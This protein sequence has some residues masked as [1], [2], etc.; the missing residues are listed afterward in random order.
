[1]DNEHSIEQSPTGNPVSKQKTSTDAEE[2]AFLLRKGLNLRPLRRSVLRNLWLVAGIVTILGS[3]AALRS[4][5]APPTYSGEF[6]LL[7]EPL[8]TEARVADP[9]AVTRTGE[10]VPNE[11]SFGL[12]YPSQ[13]AVLRSPGMM[14]LIVA[15]VQEKYPSFN[16]GTLYGGLSV[17]R[18]GETDLTHT[19]L[20]KVSYIGTD[21]E[22]V[23]LVLKKTSERYLRYSLE[24]RKT[25]YSEG[26]KF[27]DDRLPD[28]QQRVGALQDQLQKLQEQ[29]DLISP[30]DQGQLLSQQINQ[31]ALD[32]R[33]TRKQLREQTTLY[34]SLRQQ[35]T[36]TPEE[37]IAA[38]ALSEEPGYRL[39]QQQMQEIE[40]KIATESAQF[41]EESPILI[42]LRAKQQNLAK[43]LSQE[44]QR[45]LGQ[46]LNQSTSNPQV[47]AF[48]NSVRLAL[49]GQMVAATNQ[50]SVLQARSEE[51]TKIRSQV[52]NRFQKFPAVARR[53]AD[54]LSQLEISKKNLEQLLNQRETLQ[55]ES[56]Q[57]EVPWEV[58]SPPSVP[59]DADGRAIPA[60]KDRKKL[61]ASIGV[62]LMV[63]VVAAILLDKLRN[64]FH[65]TED[66][67][68]AVDLPVV[69]VI[70]FD[71]DA[72]YIQYE[73]PLV[74]EDG[75][76]DITLTL[77][78]EAFSTLYASICFLSEGTSVRSLAICSASPGE[79]KT[80]IALHLAHTV[81]SMGKNVLLV[82]SNLRHSDLH[83][84]LDL[85]NDRGLSDILLNSLEPEEF[86]QPSSINNLFVLP[87]GQASVGAIR[88]LGSKHMRNV[89]LKL[90]Q[91]FDLV[92]YDTPHLLG[93]TDAEFLSANTDGMLMIIGIRQ[94]KRS[95][96]M[97]V[98]QELTTY[99]LESL[100]IVANH[101]NP[102]SR[103][104]FGYYSS[105]Q[106]P[107]WRKSKTA[108]NPFRFRL[109]S[110]A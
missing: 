33:E 98:L 2:F 96:A 28:L 94:T 20:I 53:Y 42:T 63:G 65:T 24:D 91:T 51:I 7:V 23:E 61:L 4:A 66:I 49:I 92:I 52:E 9:R 37:A 86:I 29:Y 72:D 71:P 13:I 64:V 47:M 104:S 84:R 70:P 93:L 85:A 87:A 41:S 10:G 56:A 102:R 8:N 57:T 3:F 76:G 54:L 35:L 80:T 75:K 6:Q 36:L 26:I 16:A 31:I 108:K 82:D 62:S 50:V 17:T 78:K 40:S 97:Q 30:T 38:S 58:V 12:D 67:Q 107:I 68:D 83:N 73:R 59:K 109:K 74:L 69:G 18:I 46:N 44:A 34:G 110:K 101:P 100:G 5:S 22:L 19:K 11:N 79:G 32:E 103:A 48:Q 45:I 99:R 89:M 25:R 60:P 55:I 39:L 77:F 105:K 15:A 21:S 81:A 106:R 27:I 90:H 88:L 43:L 95:V 14:K 1:M